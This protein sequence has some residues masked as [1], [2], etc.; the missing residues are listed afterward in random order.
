MRW[1]KLKKLVE[2][3]FADS[4]KPRVAI[5]SA[6]YGACTC[7]HVWIT[8]DSKVIANFC[9]RAFYN[10]YNRYRSRDKS[11]DRGVPEKKKKQ[12]S[13]QFVEYGEMS[14]QDVYQACWEFVH[15]MSFDDAIKSEDPLIQSLMV[16]DKRLGKRRIDSLDASALHPL[17]GKLLE[18]RKTAEAIP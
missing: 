12:Y 10:R 14:R 3:N 6:A 7:G 17:A 1:S 11:K 2:N 16:L 13:G 5:H 8:L 4:V 18:I 9:T 15:D